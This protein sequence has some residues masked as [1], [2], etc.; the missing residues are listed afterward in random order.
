MRALALMAVLL[1]LGVAECA[2]QDVGKPPPP[3]PLKPGET[4]AA[5]DLFGQA[6]APA[7]LASRAIGSYARG[8]LAGAAALPVDGP[9]WQ[10]M[11]LERNRT[12]GTPV[13]VKYVERL[14]QDAK[15][16][17]GWPGLLVGDMSQPR[18]GPMI[19]GHSSHQ[20]GL[21]ADI[22]L[23]P[24]PN[25]VLSTQE[26]ATM[27]AVSM[28]KDKF[29]VDPN[30]MTMDRV[31]LI[32]RAASYPEVAR[33]FVHP[34]IKKAL[35]EA[36]GVDRGWLRK[37]R[38]WWGHNYHFHVRLR[39][40]VGMT[41]CRDQPP[42]PPGD[43]CMDQLADWFRMLRMPPKPVKP[44]PPLKL[45]DLPPDCRTVLIAG[46]KPVRTQPV[47]PRDVP[48]D[49]LPSSSE[50]TPSAVA[51]VPTPPGAVPSTTLPWFSAKPVPPAGS[52]PLPERRPAR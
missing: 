7:S 3:A 4:P 35:C 10:A 42:L 2:A 52:I 48:E 37:V 49:A 20:V 23:T 41:S 45:T 21:D 36:A 50:P 27:S 15:K 29:S 25:H 14:A 13:L 8:C 6:A 30:L 5:K 38:P 39:C 47:L 32:R 18:G 44:K 31:K 9:A 24:M 11:R 16:L 12:Y 34:A 19:T 43:G 33:I 17:D 26:R 1:T 22:W 46:S 40:P 28:L 51:P